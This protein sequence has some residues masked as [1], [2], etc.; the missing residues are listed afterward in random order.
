MAFTDQLLYVRQRSTPTVRTVPLA[1]LGG[2]KS[3]SAATFPGGQKPPGAA[4][5]GCLASAI[6]PAAGEGAALVANPADQAIYFYTEG[7]AAPMGSFTNYGH[8]PLAVMAVDRSLRPRGPGVYET[9]ARFRRP[10]EYRLIFFLDSPRMFQ[11][12]D[13]T[14]R[15]DPAKPTAA[16]DTV[17]AELLPG[18]AEPTAGQAT[19]VAFRLRDARTKAP[20]HGLTDVTVLAFSPGG[21]Q[22][23]LPTAPTAEPGTYTVEFTPPDEGV[24]YLYAEA[25][26]AGLA[27]NKA[28][29]TVLNAKGVPK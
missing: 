9:T 20:H 5:A 22:K 3:L 6:S 11:A 18:G 25:P 4:G 10:G 13:V 24:Y 23:R 17:V 7:M 15:P 1:Q 27:F 29:L 14:V 8:V 26:L 21:W 12:F 16:A 19:A 2:G 28:Q